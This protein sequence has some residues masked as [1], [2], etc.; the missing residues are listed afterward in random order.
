MRNVLKR[1]Q[2]KMNFSSI[3]FSFEVSLTY[4]NCR[5]KYYLKFNITTDLEDHQRW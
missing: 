2:K 5:K 3:K 1:M 4:K